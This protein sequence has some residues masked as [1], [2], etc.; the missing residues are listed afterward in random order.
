MPEFV[1]YHLDAKLLI[2]SHFLFIEGADTNR[3]FDCCSSH[4]C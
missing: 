3:D 1:T 2:L 4:L